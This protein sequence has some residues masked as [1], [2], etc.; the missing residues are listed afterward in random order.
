MK[1]IRIKGHRLLICA[2]HSGTIL[3]KCSECGAV[4]IANYDGAL[5]R[6]PEFVPIAEHVLIYK[7]DLDSFPEC[8]EI[9]M[10]AALK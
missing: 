6:H 1:E 3:L 10:R 7:P 4:K 8:R 5:R 9:K 2:E